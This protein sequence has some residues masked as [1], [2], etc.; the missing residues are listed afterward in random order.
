MK[1]Y[2]SS[3]KFVKCFIISYSVVIFF[4]LILV[5]AFSA[6]DFKS[7]ILATI[8]CFLLVLIGINKGKNA[9]RKFW[10]NDEGIHNRYYSIKWEEIKSYN[11]C[12]VYFCYNRTFKIHCPS[13]ICLGFYDPNKNFSKQDSSKCIFISMIPQYFDLLKQYKDRSKMICEI[14]ELYST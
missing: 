5:L 14:T 8:A 9:F 11:I 2:L 13:V 4:F 10:I 1:K 12:E 3:P 7:V 6:G